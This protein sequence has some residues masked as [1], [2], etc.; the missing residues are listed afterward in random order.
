MP[1]RVFYAY[2]EVLAPFKDDAHDPKTVLAAFLRLTTHVTNREVTD[3]RL[4]IA[5]EVR[6]R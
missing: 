4:P 5:P 6:Q 1:H 2:E 3:Y